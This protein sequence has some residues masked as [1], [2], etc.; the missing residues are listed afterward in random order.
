M[1]KENG[2][3]V[4]MAG[5]QEQKPQN[6]GPTREELYEMCVYQQ[7]QIETFDEQMRLIKIDLYRKRLDYLF[8][9]L[10]YQQ[11]F[12]TEFVDKCVNEITE[13]LTLREPKK[14]ESSKSK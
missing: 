2:K 1:E 4:N 12:K 10:E 8:K 6:A 3:V 11:L 5:N 13:A 7:K 9:V 14:K